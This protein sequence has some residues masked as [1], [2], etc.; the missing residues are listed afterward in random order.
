M[1]AVPPGRSGPGRVSPRSAELRILGLALALLVVAAGPLSRVLAGRPAA[2]RS[3]GSGPSEGRGRVAAPLAPDFPCQ[4]EARRTVAPLALVPGQAT[5]VTVQIDLR[6]EVAAWPRRLVLVLDAS[7]GMSADGLKRLKEGLIDGLEALAPHLGRGQGLAVAV[8]A[9]DGRGVLAGDLR[10]SQDLRTIQ[11]NL[12]R[13]SLGS[14]VC[15]AAPAA[16]CGAAAA[17]RQAAQL[18]ESEAAADPAADIKELLLL[19]SAGID[20]ADLTACAAL[21]QSAED[22]RLRP[23]KPLLM[24][25][26]AT[27]GLGY[28]GYRCLAEVAESEDF[29]FFSR[30]ATW[31]HF[32]TILA[33][34][35][36]GVRSFHPLRLVEAYDRVP[37][38]LEYAG[39]DPPSAISG[40]RLTWVRFP[41]E[42]QFELR[43]GYRLVPQL[44]SDEGPIPSSDDAAFSLEYRP[45][46][47]GG[48]LYSGPLDIPRLSVPCVGPSP[49]TP[50]PGGGSSATATPPTISPPPTRSATP[51]P[52]ASPDPSASADPASPS[53][54]P[55]GRR[56]AA[57]FLPLTLRRDG[58]RACP[59][60]PRDIVLLLD[61]STSMRRRPHSPDGAPPFGGQTR[62]EVAVRLIRGLLREGLAPGRDRVALVEYGRETFVSAGG[63]APCCQTVL[64]ALDALHSQSHTFPWEGLARAVAVQE[65]AEPPV[66]L[67]RRA[68]L[69]IT[70]LAAS[71]LSLADQAL[72]QEAAAAARRRGIEVLGLGIGMQADGGFLRSLAG[73]RA[74]RVVLSRDLG[75][76]AERSLADW[77]RCQP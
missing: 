54:T 42:S 38:A 3:L 8:L 49:A 12:R 29:A 16:D 41:V 65:A 55:S 28:C 71:D 11:D 7:D 10:F 9:Y 53:P 57:A 48:A 50:T 25:A 47:W 30:T 63:L 76:D 17:L 69:L 4:T 27:E 67:P 51:S 1:G 62:Q 34:L 64:A 19:A 14:R 24:S 31:Q 22:L 60:G 52:T 44:C 61:V 15:G 21:K 36:A 23:S 39:G 46:L 43:V 73:G 37:E 33:A 59:E 70:D 26:C 40:R 35:G 13:V 32:P 75:G 18:L 77:M 5:T 72:T 20:Q 45:Y 58:G 2:D 6:C 68:I 66:D 56:P 74:S